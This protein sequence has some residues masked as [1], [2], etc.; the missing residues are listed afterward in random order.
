MEL[1]EDE[2]VKGRRHI[3]GE[4]LR[5]L[6]VHEGLLQFDGHALLRLRATPG[7]ETLAIARDS[8]DWL[9]LNVTAD[10]EDSNSIQ[11]P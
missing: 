5:L 10:A 11:V 8:C 9:C 4:I 1:E 7:A 6:R 3:R 2:K